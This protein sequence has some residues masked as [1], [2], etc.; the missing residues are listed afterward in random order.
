MDINFL[1]FKICLCYDAY[2][3]AP[4]VCVPCACRARGGQ[5]RVPDPQE[6]RLQMG[7][8]PL[9]GCGETYMKGQPT[10]LTTNPFL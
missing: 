6:V 8:D 7:G 1:N 10:F 3:T 9:C 5:K 2:V 4:E